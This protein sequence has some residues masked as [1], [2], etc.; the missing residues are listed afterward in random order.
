[1]VFDQM[2]QCHDLFTNHAESQWGGAGNPSGAELK[3]LYEKRSWK[4]SFDTASSIDDPVWHGFGGDC[5]S[6]TSSESQGCPEV[7]HAFNDTP[8][9]YRRD[10]PLDEQF[11]DQPGTIDQQGFSDTSRSCQS[12]A[13]ADSATDQKR[14][15]D[16]DICP[17]CRPSWKPAIAASKDVATAAAIAAMPETLRFNAEN[18]SRLLFVKG[19]FLQVGSTSGEDHRPTRQRRSQSA[20]HSPISADVDVPQPLVIRSTPSVDSVETKLIVSTMCN[21]PCQH[22]NAAPTPQSRA[23]GFGSSVPTMDTLPES[24]WDGNIV[25]ASEH[26]SDSDDR[27][28]TSLLVAYLPRSATNADLSKVF[29][30]FGLLALVSVMRDVVGVSKCFAFVT[31]ERPEGAHAAL[32][33]CEEGRLVLPDLA[34]KMWHV[35]A[36]WAR[37]DVSRRDR[38]AKAVHAPPLALLAEDASLAHRAALDVAKLQPDFCGIAGLLEPLRSAQ[39]ASGANALPAEPASTWEAGHCPR[40]R[41]RCLLISYLPRIA[42]R[43]DL[44]SAFG[45]F[46]KIAFTSVVQD[47]RGVSKCYGFVLFKT[48]DAAEEARRHCDQERVIM[49]DDA[50][51]RWRVQA[52]WAESNRPRQQRNR[53]GTVHCSP[54]AGST[55]IAPT[56]GP[57]MGAAR[58]AA[59]NACVAPPGLWLA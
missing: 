28:R 48:A 38:R 47:L 17:S 56:Y 54:F 30:R 25:C 21:T 8:L 58:G 53:G 4:D 14:I 3:T 35:K 6:D 51:K 24:I 27:S 44:A 9:P 13:G 18:F 40:R 39:L 12:V 7:T 26:P 32:H 19:T 20:G 49:S 34:G 37:K 57:D 23:E 1:M 59:I 31:F 11:D 36:S 41:C 10:F 46:G 55:N 29:G 45:R 33:F 2:D 16:V 42:T 22:V 52:S 15:S 5:Y 43:A 50:G